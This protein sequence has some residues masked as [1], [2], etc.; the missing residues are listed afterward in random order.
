MDR[1]ASALQLL[2]AIASM[3]DC[4]AERTIVVAPREE[5]ARRL[6]EETRFF[7]G[8]SIHH[9]DRCSFYTVDELL[10]F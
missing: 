6:L 4:S 7:Y 9:P 3:L 8:S 10:I 5:D 1:L 2:L